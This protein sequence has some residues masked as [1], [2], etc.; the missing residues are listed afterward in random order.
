MDR[1][2]CQL[3]KS[4]H[5]GETAVGG[6]IRVHPP[7]RIILVFHWKNRDGIGRCD[8]RS[9]QSGF[10]DGDTS[11]APGRDLR[12]C[13]QGTSKIK[14]DGDGERRRSDCADIADGRNTLFK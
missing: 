12:C 1:V 8:L 10:L 14:A 3:L 2:L 5:K 4:L 9:R 11:G 6:R 7:A 13:W